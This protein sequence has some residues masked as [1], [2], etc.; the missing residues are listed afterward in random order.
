MPIDCPKNTNVVVNNTPDPCDGMYFSTDCISTPTAIVYL[1]LSAES[2][3]TEVNSAITL[4]LIN[5]NSRI[6]ALEAAG[7][8]FTDKTLD[9]DGTYNLQT[10]DNR[11]NIIIN[12]AV[13]VPRI[14]INSALPSNFECNLFVNGEMAETIKIEQEYDTA[15]LFVVPTVN[16]DTNDAIQTWGRVNIRRVTTTTYSAT[17][18]LFNE[19]S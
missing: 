3:Q 11:K 4:D 6:I 15:P 10:I 16:T 12:S 9:I 18:D 1:S 13:N 19:T 17:G 14:A 7:Q 2:T 8:A 5:K